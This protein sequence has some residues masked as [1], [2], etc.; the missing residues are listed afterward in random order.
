MFCDNCNNSFYGQAMSD[1]NCEMCNREIYSPHVPCYTRCKEC[2]DKFNI[3]EQCGK[4][5][6]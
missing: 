3:C 4:E 5:S 6:K 1:G 2:S